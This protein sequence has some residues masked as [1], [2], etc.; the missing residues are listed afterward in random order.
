MTIDFFRRVLA[1]G[2][3]SLL[4]IASSSTAWAQ[5]TRYVDMQIASASCST[6]EPSTR[7]CGGGSAPAYKDLQA[8]SAAAQPGDTV[9][10]RQG[11]F[12]SQ[13]APQTSGT[14]TAPIT[15]RA[16]SGETPT[17]ANV[18]DPAIY[19]LN[20]SY[21]VIDGLTVSNAL[22]WGR[23]EN[24]SFITIQNNHFSTATAT[25]TTG[26]FKLV[27]SSHNRILNNTIA[28]GNDNMLL[29]DSNYNLIAGN[30]FSQARHTLLN[31]SCSN[32]NVIR[33]NVFNNPAQKGIENFDCE[34]T[35]TNQPVKLDATKH[36]VWEANVFS[37][38][39]SGSRDYDY[40]AMQYAGQNG[41][42]RRNLYYDNLGGAINFQVYSDEA[43]YNYGH[44]V[45]HNTFYN[46]RCEAIAAAPAS[47]S[48]RYT[49]NIVKN[50]LLYK[51]VDCSGAAS[52]TSI[53]NT[54]AVALSSNAIVTASP[55]FVSESGRDLRLQS[56]SPQIDAASFL[57][58]AASAG[59]GTSLRVADA[60]YFYD[61]FGILG[62]TGDTIQL[63]GQTQ[64]AVVVAVDY[65]TN[66]LTLDRSLTWTSGQ[67][68]T[69]AYDGSA[70]DMGAYETGGSGGS[71]TPPAPPT[72]VRIVN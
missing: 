47:T 38:T 53:G 36:N 25:G 44:R 43:L 56:G 49:N 14:S 69:L 3:L 37:G 67:G 45:Y 63:A 28:D 2:S 27:S 68:V 20:R 72:N 4:T 21:L 42:V 58:T 5:T 7:N 71:N 16:Y 40:N 23:L 41:I 54:T 50:N 19:V 9:L 35:V 48:S 52:Q 10:I 17:I 55:L 11:T 12:T 59:S 6:Y 60:S 30:S 64:R 66:V 26:G 18:S 29:Q 24:A 39:K 51:N 8:A 15:Y 33:A 46:N 65:A 22:G 70:P 13:F 61:G 57:T 31:V 34:G 32:Y 1:T 62:E